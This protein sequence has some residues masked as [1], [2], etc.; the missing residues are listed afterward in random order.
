MTNRGTR[1]GRE[2]RGALGTDVTPQRRRPAS[3]GMGWDV[4]RDVT[5]GRDKGRCTD[6][7][8]DAGRDTGVTQT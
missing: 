1:C 3:H 5:Q 6:V 4:T 2:G 8:W 7:T